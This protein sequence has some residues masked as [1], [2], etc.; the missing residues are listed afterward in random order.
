MLAY[1]TSGKQVYRVFHEVLP[2]FTVN[3]REKD[4]MIDE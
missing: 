1:I 2:V 3:N 4:I